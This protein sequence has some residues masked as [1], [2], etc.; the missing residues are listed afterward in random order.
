MTDG[1]VFV[2]ADNAKKRGKIHSSEKEIG[3][4]AHLIG[5]EVEIG[6]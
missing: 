4:K 5:L 2:V 1:S 3:N 6:H